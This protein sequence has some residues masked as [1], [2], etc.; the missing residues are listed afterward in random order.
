[1]ELGVGV[2][3]GHADPGLAHLND[4]H[5]LAWAAATPCRNDQEL[6][7]IMEAI[8]QACARLVDFMAPKGSS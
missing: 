6:L 2:A 8:T 4:H 3:L 7:P 1:M 5:D